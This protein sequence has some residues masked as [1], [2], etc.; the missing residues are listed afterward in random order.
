MGIV[1]ELSPELDPVEFPDDMGPEQVE[2]YVAEK[3]DELRRR[4]IARKQAS[5]ATETE[6]EEALK[7]AM[8]E[9]SAWEQG[10]SMLRSLPQETTR[11]AGGLL[12]GLGAYLA[13]APIPRE[14][15]EVGTGVVQ[16]N[17]RR[18]QRSRRQIAE[19]IEQSAIREAG[20][21]LKEAA[22]EIFPTLPGV[23]D[24]LPSQ[25]MGGLGSIVGLAPAMVAGPAAPFVGGAMYGLSAGEDFADDARRVVNDRIAEALTNGDYDTA[26]DLER[27]KFDMEDKARQAGRVIGAATEGALGVAAKLRVGKSSIGGIGERLAE[28][29][30]AKSAPQ[31]V[32]RAVRGAV[33][34]GATEAAQEATEQ[35]LG[36]AA[37]LAV[38][39][40]DRSI[41][42]DLGQA[43]LVG[44]LT[45]GIAGGARGSDRR[46][47]LP[48]ST[49]AAAGKR[50]AQ[51]IP[52]DVGD[53]AAPDITEADVEDV[54]AGVPQ[55]PVETVAVEEPQ[56]A[57][58]ETPAAVAPVEQPAPTPVEPAP[59]SLKKPRRKRVSIEDA[60]AIEAAITATPAPEPATPPQAE[61]PRVTIPP[62]DAAS[63]TRA[64]EADIPLGVKRPAVADPKLESLSDAEFTKVRRATD[65][66]LES[67]EKRYDAEDP[68]LSRSE[69]AAAQDAFTAVE[70]ERFRRSKKGLYAPDLFYDLVKLADRARD[71]NSEAAAQAR[72]L[73]DEIQRQGMSLDQLVS[74]LS[75]SSPD[76]AEVLRG[77]AEDLKSVLGQQKPTGIES[78]AIDVESR[79]VAGQ[80]APVAGAPE[81]GIAGRVAADLAMEQA[82]ARTPQTPAAPVTAPDAGIAERVAA[83][84]EMEQATAQAG[85][86][87]ADAALNVAPEEGFAQIDRS[88]P[89]ANPEPQPQ[90]LTPK[91]YH[92]A[93]NEWRAK[94]YGVPVSEVEEQYPETSNTQD[95]WQRVSTFAE[96]GGKLTEKVLDSL[97]EEQIQYLQ[98]SARASIPE[99]YL[100]P[101]VRAKNKAFEREMIDARKRGREAAKVPVPT[102]A[103]V[104]YEAAK[105][106]LDALG[107][108]PRKPSNE[109]QRFGTQGRAKASPEAVARYDAEVKAY[110]NWR[111]KYSKL[112][113]A[114]VEA[115][116]AVYRE[117]PEYFNRRRAAAVAAEPTVTEPAPNQSKQVATRQPKSNALAAQEIR[118]ETPYVR[119]D[120]NSYVESA[121]SPLVLPEDPTKQQ[122]FFVGFANF[123][124]SR[125]R[126]KYGGNL[127]ESLERT[128]K[129]PETGKDRSFIQDEA[130]KIAREA[131]GVIGGRVRLKLNEFLDSVEPGLRKVGATSEDITKFRDKIDSTAGM[132]ANLVAG[133]SPRIGPEVLGFDLGLTEKL[134]TTAHGLVR[135][136]VQAIKPSLADPSTI[137]G[138]VFEIMGGN[139]FTQTRQEQSR[140]LIE[141]ASPSDNPAQKRE[142]KPD[143]I[144]RALDAAIKA[145]DPKSATFSDPFLIAAV[146]L[147][148]LNAALRLARRVYLRTRNLVRAKQQGM[149]LIRRRQRTIPPA[150]LPKIEEAFSNLVDN[151]ITEGPPPQTVTP[152]SPL[153]GGPRRASRGLFK[154]DVTIDS[155]AQWQAQ[156]DEWIAQF[157]GNLR[158]AFE[159]ARSTDFQTT[160]LNQSAQYYVFGKL[161]ELSEIAAN[162]ARNDVDMLRHLNLQKEIAEA[163]KFDAAE[164]GKTLAAA[165]LVQNRLQWMFPVLTYRNLIREAQKRLPFPDVVA[166]EVR[167]WLAESGRR[168]VQE[169]RNAMTDADKVFARELKS[170]VRD[171]RV[172]WR[173]VMTASVESQEN[174]RRKI[175]E[176]LVKAPELK[177][178]SRQGYIDIANLLGKA[179]EKERARIFQAEFRKQVPLPSVKEDD[180]RKLFTAIPNILKW[181]NLGLLDNEAF[182]NAIA[183]QYGVA[184]FDG[185]TAKKLNTMAQEAQKVGG[186]NRNRLIMDMYNVMQQ[187]GG[188]RAADVFRD[189]WYAAVLSG[190]RTQV[191]NAMNILTGALTSAMGITMAKSEARGAI[192]KAYGKGLAE[193]VHDFWPI[194]W[195]GELWRNVNFN[196]NQPANTLEAI[197]KSGNVFAKALGQFK[198]VGRLMNALDHINALSSE[199]AMMA[200]ALSRRLPIEH[201]HRYMTPSE[202]VLRQARAR[203][204][205]EG[206]A[207][208]LM[209]KRV[210][211]IVQESV[212]VEILISARDLR[213]LVTFTNQPKGVMGGLYRGI[214]EME[215][216]A[217]GF[218]M[219]SGT[220]FVRFAGN[221]TN[222][223][224]NYVAPVA[225]YRY[226]MSAPSRQGGRGGLKMGEE[227]R[228]LILAK[229]ALGFAL[230]VMAGALFLGDDDEEKDRDIDITGS[231]KSLDPNKRRQVISE[232]RQPYSIRF[233][234]TYVSYRQLPFGGVLGAI[235]ELRDRQLFNKEEWNKESLA[236]KVADAGMAGAFIVRDSSAISGLTEFLGFANAYK[237][238]MNDNIERTMPKYMAKLAGSV[239][240]NIAKEIDAWSDPSIYK[241]DTGHEYFLQQMPYMRRELGAGPVLNVLGEPVQVE[242]YPW[243]RWIKTR[244]ED[245]AWTTLGTLA[246]RGVFLPVPSANVK[247]LENG[248][249]R[250]MTP[251]EQHAYQKRVGAD[252]RKFVEENSQ[253]LLQMKPEQAVEFIDK[254]TERI[255][256]RND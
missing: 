89:A 251:Q 195:R 126:R 28:R 210:R 222:E 157:N 175:L 98:R 156:A 112:K 57:P 102:K 91:Q 122:Q 206:T 173:D 26:A 20:T 32:Q 180:R 254:Q 38:Y 72:I 184:K 193:A 45:G 245:K 168:A 31:M 48:R 51:V 2:A 132:V 134:W 99:G 67:L 248:K 165:N 159:A 194:L 208:D 229:L 237:Y 174:M 146:G 66:N 60:D 110:K 103:Q 246:S 6:G 225:L 50:V 78:Q 226:Y 93:I 138:L 107:P 151:G 76:E 44:G 116:N 40:P 9:M 105:A 163:M 191:D 178:L 16:E 214:Q 79:Q 87:P 247:V 252:Y 231:F 197:S 3:G 12:E 120:Y 141:G 30:V 238:D 111:A 27:R 90:S 219:L 211:E 233:G 17:L 131:G 24:S 249:R 188:V 80:P 81:E 158:R 149:R 215:K 199:Q 52:Q 145:T 33:E 148:V 86:T 39:D 176:E 49:A 97:D 204:E 162:A 92:K 161:L 227:E 96:R 7:Y 256:R 220:Q 125:L 239:I 228:Q 172:V 232:G 119:G 218:K 21:G 71:P 13:E 127:K 133:A 216:A 55:A 130:N 69:L 4:L 108:E 64:A 10:G 1:R 18:Q 171:M 118:T 169:M 201:L 11:F 25:V 73:I 223:I 34:G 70:L 84:A 243:S 234:D 95:Y 63:A 217:P 106:K 203:A 240:P 115:S 241:A 177:G 155:D 160:G 143:I 244:R 117:D 181:A 19:E 23:R 140:P 153:P 192:A 186:S 242:R 82:T 189:Y 101:A 37:A 47:P 213:Q 255:R 250:P 187:E 15:G 58:V 68:T 136:A 207:P 36:N 154:G 43:A 104:A 94:E 221:Y 135:D 198:Y 65:A 236:R 54:F 235:G 137:D 88:A 142:S 185:E 129:D 167:T 14:R 230:G 5:M 121:L 196:P 179:W 152:A 41:M 85:Q 35:A 183:P 128:N 74:E 59:A 253:R 100:S 209:D 147:P 144:Q 200:W 166:D 77:Q 212:P 114:Q 56:P 75:A 205:A 170:T 109:R 22:P 113:K 224:L 42:E 53:I 123:I 150:D 46:N 202:T 62:D 61:A 139:A 83:D 29:L 8:G 182:R 164:A 190:I 124:R